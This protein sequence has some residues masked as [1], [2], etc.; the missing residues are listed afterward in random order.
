MKTLD[1]PDFYGT[2][3]FC[4]DIRYEIGGKIS[5]IGVYGQQIFL[6]GAFPFTLAKLGISI[7]YVQRQ[8][9]VVMPAAVL[10]FLPGDPDDTPSIRG[11]ISMEEVPVESTQDDS[12][13]AIM[14]LN[15]LL[16]SLVIKEP[17]SIRVRIERDGS[18][19]KVGALSVAQAPQSSS[20]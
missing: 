20:S 2:T 14:G 12:K 11:E 7:T 3:V 10:I 6:H 19:V 18:L 1:F 15:F 9:K 17:G 8:T 16:P 13:V 5:L 4:D